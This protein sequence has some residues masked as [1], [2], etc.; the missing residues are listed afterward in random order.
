[1]E[2]ARANGC[3]YCVPAH[4]Q[5]ARNLGVDPDLIERVARGE[6]LEGTVRPAVIQ[7]LVRRL[8]ATKGKLKDQEF[9]AFQ[10]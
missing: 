2:M 4:R 10:D 8:V 6:T 1:M 7:R 3:H 5:A 9:R